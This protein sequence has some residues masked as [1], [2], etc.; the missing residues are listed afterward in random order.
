M[1]GRTV[2]G[3]KLQSGSLAYEAVS[4]NFYVIQ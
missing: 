4:H 2:Y 1:T 3:S